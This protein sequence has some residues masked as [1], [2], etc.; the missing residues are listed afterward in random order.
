LETRVKELTGWAQSLEDSLREE[1]N[2]FAKLRG[3]FEERTQWA[4]AL[5][6]ELKQ[7]RVQI[8][9]LRNDL[10]SAH[11]AGD[12]AAPKSSIRIFVSLWKY[13]I[14]FCHGMD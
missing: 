10:S 2:Q 6:D 3:E 9:G 5:E 4:L 14:R 7:A 12:E 8:N 11:T 13:F 1:R